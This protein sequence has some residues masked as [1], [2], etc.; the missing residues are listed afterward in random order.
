V[1]LSQLN[2]ICDRIRQAWDVKDEAREQ[3][4][5]LARIVIRNSAN[6][7]RAVHRSEFDEARALTG[8]STDL[9]AKVK[10]HLRDQPDIFHAGFVHDAQKEHVE[11]LV[12]YALVRR[13]ALPD[14]DELGVEYA[15]YLAGVAEAVGEIR[16]HTLDRI[17]RAEPG[18][19]EEMLQV[20]DDIYYFLVSF[21]Y[22][23]AIA[24]G[25]RRLTDVMRSLI[26]R[27]RGD[28]TNAARQQ[29]LEKAMTEFEAR[30]G[31]TAEGKAGEA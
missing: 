22:P 9:L 1:D 20:M 31:I 5:T 21:D 3:G 17:R 24:G 27:T 25:L 11:A 26:E 30:L 10:E 7:I 15:A 6:S 19:G 29:R 23:P 8:A 28:L 13:E 14:P 18:W 4:L 12:T 2:Q 16:R